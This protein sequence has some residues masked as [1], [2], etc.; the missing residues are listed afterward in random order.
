MHRFMQNLSIPHSANQLYSMA[1]ILQAIVLDFLADMNRLK[2]LEHIT[3]D[4]LAQHLLSLN[5]KI[6]IDAIRYL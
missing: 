1:Q 3:L 2:K 5:K 4:K 6:G